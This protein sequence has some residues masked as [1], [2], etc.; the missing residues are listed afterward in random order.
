MS[1]W[2]GNSKAVPRAAMPRLSSFHTRKPRLASRL[3]RGET[4]SHVFVTV[5]A[6][7]PP[8]TLTITG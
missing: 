2:I 1:R 8:Y 4:C 6:C 7:G 5:C 3:S